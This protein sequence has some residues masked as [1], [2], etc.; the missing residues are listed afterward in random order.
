MIILSTNDNKKVEFTDKEAL[1]SVFLK[2][3]FYTNDDEFIN[4]ESKINVDTILIEKANEKILTKIQKLCK[5]L[6]DKKITMYKI[7]N[8]N[9]ENLD[10]NIQNILKIQEDFTVKE[11]FSLIDVV[12]FMNI[13]TI[14]EIIKKKIKY[15]ISSN[16]YDEVIKI[17]KITKDEFTNKEKEAM[18]TFDKT[19]EY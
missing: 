14:L 7:N 5:I 10:I 19:F 8:T 1:L 18:Q 9:Y 2:T 17:F 6:V 11:M 3:M 12:N 15:I 13:E 16:T 4:G